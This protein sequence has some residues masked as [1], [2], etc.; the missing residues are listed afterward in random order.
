M[1]TTIAELAE[2]VREMRKQQNQYFRT[3]SKGA[4]IASKELEKEVDA[5]VK[6]IPAPRKLEQIPLFENV[7]GRV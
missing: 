3:K 5:L 6:D 1:Q 2:K 7:E 4:L